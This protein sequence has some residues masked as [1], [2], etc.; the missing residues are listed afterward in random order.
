MF[1]KVL[2]ISTVL[3]A[4][5]MLALGVKM[6]FDKN[7]EFTAHTCAAGSENKNDQETGCSMCQL[8]E[9]SDCDEK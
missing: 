6:L 7:A 3:F 2:I 1:I 8:K 4:I 5:M 9:L